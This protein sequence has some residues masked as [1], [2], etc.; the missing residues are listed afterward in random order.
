MQRIHRV[1]KER[2]IGATCKQQ[3]NRTGAD[4]PTKKHGRVRI[5]SDS[6]SSSLAENV[7]K[8]R[9]R[10]HTTATHQGTPNRTQR[11][12][13]E[14]HQKS[15]RIGEPDRATA[16]DLD[17]A[18]VS[19]SPMEHLLNW[20]RPSTDIVPSKTGRQRCGSESQSCAQSRNA[21]RQ[22]GSPLEHLFLAPSVKRAWNTFTDGEA[23]T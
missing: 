23:I 15:K 6:M 13:N 3:V 12:E 10:H 16:H 21:R 8:K 11:S 7:S 19:D 4:N 2:P 9:E 5:T 20:R 22:S 14:T 18:R 17:Y 1:K